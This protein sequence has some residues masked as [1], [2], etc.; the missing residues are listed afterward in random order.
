M[1]TR[2]LII[3]VL[4]VLV[5]GILVGGLSGIAAAA[6]CGADDAGDFAGNC[7]TNDNQVQCGADPMVGPGGVRVNPG[8]V[9]VAANLDLE[10]EVTVCNDTLPV[11][12]GRAAV[13]TNRPQN[14]DA[15]STVPGSACYDRPCEHR[16]SGGI[17]IILD[18]DADNPEGMTG[19]W[20]PAIF[21][22]GYVRSDCPE[23]G[24]GKENAWRDVGWDGCNPLLNV[25]M[26][27]WNG[28]LKPF[29]EHM[30]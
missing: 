13:Y 1:S 30:F 11:L 7:E 2:K 5:A 25:V 12:Q 29:L 20:R 17:G 14:S 16:T 10:S 18:G 24:K 6:D 28:T 15:F 9:G 22:E 27:L 3:P 8:L 21:S 19:Y 26:D 4:V 23:P